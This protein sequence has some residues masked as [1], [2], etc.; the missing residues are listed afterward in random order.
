MSLVT[1]TELSSTIRTLVDQVGPSVVGVNGR[2]CGIVVGTG[3][4]VTNT[5][6]LTGR[7]AELDLGDGQ[8]VTATLAGADLDGDIAVL[9]ADTGDVTPLE[10]V[11]GDV[12]VGDVVFG[13]SR[14]RGG[15]LRVTVG[16]VSSLGRAFR[17]PR[18]RRI[19]G[20][21]EH[22][23]PLP[24]GSSGGPIV[25][26]AGR[27][28]GLNTHRVEDGFY[29]ALPSGED[30]RRFIA[31]ALAG[32]LAPRRSLGIAVVPPVAA[33]RLRLAV[34]LPPIDAPLVR[35]VEDGGPAG[36]AGIRRGDVI[37]GIGDANIASVDELHSALAGAA[38]SIQVR[39]VRGSD[40]IEVLVEFEPDGGGDV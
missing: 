26:A 2:G 19:T 40:E 8:V 6:N 21:V 37:V 34:G 25:D 13:L 23:A 4:I 18:G 3:L 15:A 11:E 17:G 33:R 12:E 22:T 24:R 16:T 29:L 35:T 1:P 9:R 31:E 20:G 14:P 30:F 7:E 32:E 27:L 39:V 38:S 10:D 36:R 28:V 5:H